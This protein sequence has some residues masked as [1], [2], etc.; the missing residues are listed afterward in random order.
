VHDFA[1][2]KWLSPSILPN[3]NNWQFRFFKEA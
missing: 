3:G 1:H 2:A